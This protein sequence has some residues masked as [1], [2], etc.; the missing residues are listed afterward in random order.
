MGHPGISSFRHRRGVFHRRRVERYLKAFVRSLWRPRITSYIFQSRL[1]IPLRN[2]RHKID[3][4]LA[5][6]ESA[7]RSLA[8][9]PDL[10]NWSYLRTFP[11]LIRQA[12]RQL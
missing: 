2:H 12:D 1:G 9:R 6:P 5:A 3:R 10:A 4:D 11:Y 7:M 8:S